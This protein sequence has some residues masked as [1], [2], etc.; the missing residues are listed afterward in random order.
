LPLEQVVRIA[1]GRRQPH[2]LDVAAR[3]PHD[4]L[5][6]REQVP[7]AIISR[8]ALPSNRL[9]PLNN[10]WCSAGREKHHFERFRRREASTDLRGWR[11]APNRQHPRA[12][13]GPTPAVPRVTLCRA[14]DF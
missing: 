7:T 5:K 2:A 12:D 6:D 11:A 8:R 3:E 10:V 9:N 13:G 1:D 4:P 14:Q